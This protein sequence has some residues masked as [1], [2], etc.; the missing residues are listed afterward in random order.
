MVC[1]CGGLASGRTEARAIAPGLPSLAEQERRDQVPRGTYTRLAEAGTLTTDGAR[2]VPRAAALVDALRPWGP[3][4]VVCDRFRL[5]ELQDAGPGLRLVPR[6]ARWSSASEDIRALRRSAADGPLSVAR[7]SRALLAA[8]LAVATVKT[9][10][11]GGVRLAKRGTN[12]QGRDDVAAALVL[13]AGAVSRLPVR[14][15]VRMHVA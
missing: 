5:A 2:R 13:A 15:P 12:N 3:L 4:V 6:V 14:R 7:E 10:D 1:R 11:Q 8:S 9:D